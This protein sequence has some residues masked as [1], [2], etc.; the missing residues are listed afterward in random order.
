MENK[1]AKGLFFKLPHDN[2]PDYVK[3]TLLINPKDAIEFIKEH[4]DQKWLALDMKVSKEGKPYLSINDF[5]P[6]PN[7]RK[8]NK[9]ITE[10][11]SEG[12]ENLPF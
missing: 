1:F 4:Q 9:E 3:G 5:K 6:D 8:E 10:A 2:A 7:Y 12:D 11:P